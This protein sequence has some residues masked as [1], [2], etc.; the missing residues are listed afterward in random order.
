MPVAAPVN[1]VGA[2]AVEDVS[3]GSVAVVARPAQHCKLSFDLPRE[4]DP[5]SVE[6]KECVLKL[7][8]SLEIVSVANAY[9]RPVITVAPGYVESVFQEDDSG[10]VSVN[11]SADFRV[12]GI[13]FDSLLIYVPRES[14]F[15]S[16]RVKLH[17]KLF[18]IYTEYS[19]EFIFVGYDSTV[20]DA[21]C[22]SHRFPCDE[23][24]FR[25]SPDR[26]EI[27]FGS[28]LPGEIFEFMSEYCDRQRDPLLP[29]SYMA[30]T[31]SL[32]T[33]AVGRTIFLNTLFWVSLNLS[34]SSWAAALPISILGCET[35]VNAGI[36]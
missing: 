25:V 24:V 12:F 9:G 7:I 5:V 15:A 34:M 26:F 1:H 33:R 3:K 29:L 4:E 10:I 27:I 6:G 18:R 28:L 17:D 20:E 23:G 8:K 13:K 30:L 16:S 35:V 2:L 36:V 31:E 32:S 14:V 22:A 21:V 19:P 11:E